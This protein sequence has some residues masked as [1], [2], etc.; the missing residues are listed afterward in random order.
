M[1]KTLGIKRSNFRKL[2]TLD[3][4]DI[5]EEVNDITG[6][7]APVFHG[8]H[9]LVQAKC[10]KFRLNLDIPNLYCTEIIDKVSDEII[11][12]YYDWQSSSDTLMKF[13]AHY[14]PDEAPQEVKQYDPF[15]LHLKI[16][17][18]DSEAKKREPDTQYKCLYNVLYFIKKQAYIKEYSAK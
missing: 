16:D 17:K 8:P 4:K 15:H 7:K 2:E 14:H 5:I 11:E 13:H 18:N 9:V 6:K 10:I 1:E 3:F 12:Y